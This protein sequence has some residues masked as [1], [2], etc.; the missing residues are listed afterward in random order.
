M[1][2]VIV[3]TAALTFL[4]LAIACQ[5][6]Q[7][8]DAPER[9][10]S[11]LRTLE[12]RDASR[13]QTIGRAT[14]AAYSSY[15]PAYSVFENDV[16]GQPLPI[17][18]IGTK[19]KISIDFSTLYAKKGDTSAIL[20]VGVEQEGGYI[21]GTG[22]YWDAIGLQW[23]PY[24]LEGGR[25][26]GS[27]YI[28]DS[29]KASVALALDRLKIN[30]GKNYILTY[31]CKKYPAYDNGFKCG[32][33]SADGPCNQWMI[34]F[35]TVKE[36]PDEPGG[37]GETPLEPLGIS[38][39][40]DKDTYILGE[41][42]KLSRSINLGSL[43][44]GI[45]PEETTIGYIVEFEEKSLIE[46]KLELEEQ[47]ASSLIGHAFISNAL[48][49]HEK[50]II[51]QHTDF[52]KALSSNQITGNAIAQLS[53]DT[54]EDDAIDDDALNDDALK[55]DAII[56][57]YTNAFN[58]MALDISEK[59]AEQI[60]NM[61]GVKA[62]YPNKKVR[63]LLMDA[64]PLIRA[65]KVWLQDKD[66]N[67][68]GSTECLTGKDV[69]I[70][71]IDT[72][73]DYRHPDFGSCMAT[74]NINDRSCPKVIGGKD[75]INNDNDPIDDNGHGT[76][77]AGIAAANGGLKGVAPDA[78][79]IA[80]KVLDDQGS[81]D[82]ADVLAAVNDAVDP[83]G[84]GDFSDKADIISISLGDPENPSPDDPLSRAID[85]VVE[86]GIVA[87][88]AAGNNPGAGTINSPGTARKAIT[89][90][91]FCSDDQIGNQCDGPIAPFSSEGPTSLL[92]IKPDVVAPAVDICSAR[93]D[94]IMVSSVCFDSSHISLDGTSMAAPVVSGL[95]A[96]LKQQH[97]EWTPGEI[98]MAIRKGAIDLGQ[99][100]TGQGYGRVDAL[101][102]AS[103][104][105]APCFAEISNVDAAGDN[106]FI[107]IRGSAACREGLDK[108]KLEYGA[109]TMPSQ[110]KLILESAQEKNNENL[111]DNF[112]TAIADGGSISTLR[113]TVQSSQGIVTEDRIFFK[114]TAAPSA[115]CDDAVENGMETDVDCGGG[116]CNACS[117][118][119]RCAMNPDC[120]TG[121]VC[122][123]GAC[124]EPRLPSLI[125]NPNK[126]PVE[127]KLTLRVERYTDEN[128]N[129]DREEEKI[130]VDNKQV[131]IEASSVLPLDVEWS[132]A[133]GY[134]ATKTGKFIIVAQ[135]ATES[136]AYSAE[137]GFIIP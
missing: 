92:T 97:P 134:T 136:D 46:K 127:G 27:N 73:I 39:A 128:I 31:T 102:S 108:W 38:L 7:L 90:G 81:G 58:G 52:L 107:S 17:F 56:G 43:S 80:Y 137:A 15:A 1:K 117:A 114:S 99:E 84:D 115:R 135:F 26:A 112:D 66:G 118:G 75:F 93:F 130:V 5:T 119:Q 54:V 2:K 45:G 4:I 122:N 82:L 96:L 50:K 9:P 71:V 104:L 126:K 85:N 3:L 34:H 79:L 48:E 42:V 55:D 19:D 11:P 59:T 89:I 111:Y 53:E 74:D 20:E 16:D 101:A 35:F 13:S 76:H 77:V 86:A 95:A 67:S 110:W 88:V 109:G 83:D 103:S 29:A 36:L 10:G 18:T 23:I 78:K 30:K 32:C 14:T 106:G 63:A 65:D 51:R 28:A 124:S 49:Q 100:L 94:S 123:A 87:V 44:R 68:C 21:W 40:A 57:E 22:Y 62:V 61:D 113:L 69:T 72:G 25:V 24:E 47:Q 131:R 105:H 60:S 70:A 8:P 121:L 91:G 132:D 37:P 64:V 98:K 120:D 12:T 6:S 129:E 33:S 125:K 133:G 41:T 116:E